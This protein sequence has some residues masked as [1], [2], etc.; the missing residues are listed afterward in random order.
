M[1]QGLH[2]FKPDEACNAELKLTVVPD[3]FDAS[4]MPELDIFQISFWDEVH[5]EQVV[6]VAGDIT[7]AFPRDADGV[8]MEDGV[9]ADQAERLHMKY[10]EQGRFA[11]GVAAVKLTDGS[12]KGRRCLTYNYT[13]K[14]VITI[15]T[16]ECMVKAEI[17]RVRALTGLG[18]GWIVDNRVEGERWDGDLLKRTKGIGV[19]KA[20][21]DI[22]LSYGVD[23]VGKLRNMTVEKK[24]E[25]IDGKKMSET[26][27]G[28][29]QNNVKDS[30]K[31]NTPTNLRVDHKKAA[32][33]YLSRYGADDW[34]AEI[35][36]TSAFK[37]TVCITKVIEHIIR[38]SANVFK[39][40]VHESSWYF[41]HDALSQMTCVKTKEWMEKTGYIARWIL[42]LNGLSAG[43]IYAQRP[44][45]DSPELMPLDTVLFMDVHASTVR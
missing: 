43:T 17:A 12:T 27:L 29:L 34:D 16:D 26:I 40:T 11:V 14:N 31:G 33:P 45:G 7:Y 1:R 4:K 13:G 8:Y 28:T 5:R 25:I 21:Y 35:H 6:G 15:S 22:L 24:Q 19:G 30:H 39:G 10:S 23:T 36:D 3:C 42:P 20:R 38:E 18:G 2:E 9:V 41:Y 32:N 37:R 44:P